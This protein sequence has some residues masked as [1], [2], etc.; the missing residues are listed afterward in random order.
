MYMILLRLLFCLS[1]PFLFCHHLYAQNLPKKIDRKITKGE[2]KAALRALNIEIDVIGTM[3]PISIEL[4]ELLSYRAQVNEQLEHIEDYNKDTKQLATLSKRLKSASKTEYAQGLYWTARAF[5]YAGYA[6]QSQNYLDTLLASDTTLYKSNRNLFLQTKVLQ[7]ENWLL[8]GFYNKVFNFYTTQADNYYDA[9]SKWE[10]VNGEEI[11]VDKK[12]RKFRRKLL[13]QLE[14]INVDAEVASGREK[15]I[16]NAIEDAFRAIKHAIGG[17]SDI[18]SRVSILEGDYYFGEKNYKK[19]FKIYREAYNDAKGKKYENQRLIAKAKVVEA[20]IARGQTKVASHYANELMKASR[21]YDRT[22]FKY[23][24]AYMKETQNLLEDFDFDKAMKRYNRILAK[25]E[26]NIPAERLQT[27]DFIKT[28]GLLL[29]KNYQINAAIDTL[30]TVENIYKKMLGDAAPRYHLARLQYANLLVDFSNDFKKTGKIYQ[31]SFDKVVAIEYPIANPEYYK[32]LDHYASYYIQIEEFNKAEDLLDKAGED[33]ALRYGTESPE[34]LNQ[35]NMATVVSMREGDYALAGKISDEIIKTINSVSAKKNLE[36][37]EAYDCIVEFKSIYGDFR[38]AEKFAKRA[39]KIAES[40]DYKD[41][42]VAFVANDA[43]GSLYIKT[44]NYGKAAKILADNL[45][46]K[47]KALGNDNKKLV[48]TLNELGFAALYNG[49]YVTAEKSFFRA[50]EIAIAVYGANSLVNADIISHQV[51]FYLSI[52][53][54]VKAQKLAKTV[55]EIRKSKLTGN[56]V[57]IAAAYADIASVMN[58]NGAPQNEVKPFLDKSAQTYKDAIGTNTPQYANALKDIAISEINRKKYTRA[59]SLLRVADKIWSSKL[60]EK[61]VYSAEVAILQGN[62]YKIQGKYDLAEESFKKA[63]KIYAN[64]FGEKHPQY[65]RTLSKLGQIYYIKGDYKKAIR[66]MDDAVMNYI[67]FTKIYFPALSFNEK[68]RYWNLIKED[69]EFYNSLMLKANAE[70][71]EITAKVFD[72]TLATKALLL[73][74]S[75]KLRE[76]ILSSQNQDLINKYNNWLSHKELLSTTVTL[77]SEQLIDAGINIEQ[78]QKE[79]EQEERNLSESSD[80][81]KKDKDSKQYGWK[82]LK[83]SLLAKETAVEVIRFRYYD[84]DFSDSVIYAGLV[85]DQTCDKYPKMVVLPKGKNME[86]R[87]FAYYKNCV[88]FRYEDQASYNQFWGPF[89]KEIP[90]GNTVFFSNDGVYNQLNLEALE[91]P[92]GKYVMDQNNVYVITSTREV[93]SSRIVGNKPPV[94]K[95]NALLCGNPQFYKNDEGKVSIKSLPGAE[96]EIR[97]INQLLKAKGWQTEALIGRMASKDSVKFFKNPRVFHIA[98][99]G[100]FKEDQAQTDLSANQNMVGSE[101]L[102]NP[103]LRSGLLLEGAGDDLDNSSNGQGGI[104]TA[105][106]AMNLSLDN[107]ELVVLSACET[108]RGQVQVGEG[109]YGLQRAFISAG[110]HSLVMSL[111]K[112]DDEV[113][114]QLMNVFY[115]EW[116]KTGKK[117]EAFAKARQEVRKDHPDTI[118]WGAFVMIGM[119]Y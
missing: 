70:Y 11:K 60:G 28:Y 105:Y 79:I 50:S 62:I 15:D 96:E 34:Y 90:D 63:Q 44:G 91:A 18:K 58:F 6:Y 29:L 45:A 61:N 95:L 57:D 47:K 98:T 114:K 26:Y 94:V 85:V 38:D 100:Y 51:K 10:V 48:I 24:S 113:T 80:A 119:D 39:S 46:E 12:S 2:Y 56:H 16:E 53:D 1:I 84:K 14:A 66:V 67:E 75:V 89:K 106:E 40:I 30:K 54:N 22:S 109:V 64:T 19:A 88:K 65:V 68:T 74:S 8:Q 9:T 21:Y 3:K 78:L 37:I 73:S 82:D 117:R 102:Q 7:A 83:K 55:L 32:I 23:L 41:K 99:H 59:D 118:Y 116:L 69:F 49:D 27:A 107:T 72:I 13:A 17:K 93:I 115:T 33:V 76:E 111:F 97:E 71:P 86:G 35:I 36:T 110:A 101:I 20:A 77:T 81:F 43:L 4:A 42:E 87:D 112:I 108:G 92:D 103:L 52:G 104:L 5:N 31:E 25:R